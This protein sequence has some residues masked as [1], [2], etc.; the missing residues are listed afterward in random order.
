MNKEYYVPKI[1]E[2]HVGFECEYYNSYSKKFNPMEIDETNYYT[3]ELGEY[4]VNYLF[5][6][7]GENKFRVKYLGKDDIE[8]LGWEYSGKSIDEWFNKKGKFH[9]GS[10]TSYLIKL[11]YGVHDHRLYIIAMDMGDEHKIF[12]GVI[13]NKSELEVL[14]RQLGIKE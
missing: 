13:N 7:R 5:S 4:D 8:E 6:Y 12:E 3:D 2:F 11:H 9:I 14:M 1:E 10:W